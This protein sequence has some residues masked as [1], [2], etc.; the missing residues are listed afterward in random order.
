LG[1]KLVI[2]PKDGS[3]LEEKVKAEIVKMIEKSPDSVYA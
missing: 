2:I 3:E 1:E